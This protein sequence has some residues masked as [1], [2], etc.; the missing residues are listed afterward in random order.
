M[1]NCLKLYEIVNFYAIA[2][3]FNGLWLSNEFDLFN[4]SEN[5][6][7]ISLLDAMEEK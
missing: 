3:G 6:L 7:V 4:C 5:I 1:K 2:H